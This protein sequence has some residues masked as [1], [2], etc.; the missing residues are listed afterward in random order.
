MSNELPDDLT[1]DSVDKVLENLTKI[2]NYSH[3]ANSR[4][5]YFAALYF[6]VTVA[7]RDACRPPDPPRPFSWLTFDCPT[8]MESF[9]V[10]FANRYLAA[11]DSY[12][13]GKPLTK[14]WQLSFDAAPSGTYS[15]MQQL[16]LGMSAHIMLDLG[17]AGAE[18]C[19]TQEA[20]D[21]F[22][23]DFDKVNWILASVVPFMDC[24]LDSLSEVYEK[25]SHRKI[26]RV[27]VDSAMVL[28]REVCWSFAERLVSLG[29]EEQKRAIAARDTF[30]MELGKE[31]V[32]HMGPIYT[33]M[34]AV[35]EKDIAHIIEVLASTDECTRD[36]LRSA[37][38][39]HLS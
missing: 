17:I 27:M 12:R 3:D 8:R 4:M 19:P 10:I 38:A 5:G 18:L 24:K 35:E 34:A 30:T 9:D 20:L 25:L 7:I 32:M 1:A 13:H 11:Y 29:P 16:M 21:A 2:A 28:V 31:I 33:E 39:R 23:D 36:F 22:K 15:I 37:A 6:H 26:E 14:S